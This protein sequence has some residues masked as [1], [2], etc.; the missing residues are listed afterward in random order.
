MISKKS[1]VAATKTFRQLPVNFRGSGNANV[2]E[3]LSSATLS[4][5]YNSA[6]FTSSINEI[7]P[8]R[9]NLPQV[10]NPWRNPNTF[11]DS[12]L[13]LNL[14]A[15]IITQLSLSHNSSATSGFI[16]GNNRAYF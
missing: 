15:I 8:Q 6:N 11:A 2:A 12:R 7:R 3:Q 13:R 1:L 4:L 10:K 16:V 14:N 5:F 9:V